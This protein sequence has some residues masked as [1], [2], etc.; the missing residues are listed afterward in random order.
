M[1]KFRAW[2]SKHTG[3]TTLAATAI[4]MISMAT[5]FQGCVRYID[6]QGET[7]TK[8]SEETTDVLDKGA[9]LAPVVTDTLIG[10]GIAIPGFA[11]LAGVLA[12]AI[13]AFF[14]AYKRYRPQIIEEH[15]TAV[16]FGDMTKAL[17]YAIE[18]FK[19]SNGDDWGK[20]TH[21]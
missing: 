12:G 2:I 4:I 15:E 10:V 18:R 19:L 13:T 8:L 1:K 6:T 14:G 20:V 3:L 9:E 7:V 16:M 21:Q 5:S 11:A 17:V